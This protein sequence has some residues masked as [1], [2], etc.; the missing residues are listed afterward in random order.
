[1]D[2]HGPHAWSWCWKCV[3]R[4]KMIGFVFKHILLTHLRFG[5][6]CKCSSVPAAP[7]SSMRDSSGA[8]V[9]AGR[10][11]FSQRFSFSCIWTSEHVYSFLGCFQTLSKCGRKDRKDM[12]AMSLKAWCTCFLAS[13][14]TYII[15]VLSRRRGVWSV[16][17]SCSSLFLFSRTASR[18]E[19]VHGFS[20]ARQSRRSME[21][22]G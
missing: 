10:C 17:G 12:E 7:I 1:M 4:V 22:I 14:S 9:V 2:M 18:S 11:T 15:V 20:S 8:R 6:R 3:R 21:V 5:P 16:S 19:E 13:F